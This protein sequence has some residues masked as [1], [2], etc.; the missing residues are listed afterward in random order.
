MTP[1]TS[2]TLTLSSP[3]SPCPVSCIRD[4]AVCGCTVRNE[5][6]IHVYVWFIYPCKDTTIE[7]TIKI[8]KTFSNTLLNVIMFKLSEMILKVTYWTLR[9]L[10]K[11]E[12][13]VRIGAL[14]L[15]WRVQISKV[16]YLALMIWCAAN[17]GKQT[18]KCEFLQFILVFVCYARIT[19]MQW[20]DNSNI[21]ID[22]DTQVN[23]LP[24]AC[25]NK[26]CFRVGGQITQ[27]R[28]YGQRSG[29][30]Q[31]VWGLFIRPRRTI[32][33][34]NDYRLPS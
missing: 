17:S 11:L 7:T 5:H 29:L 2:S 16:K 26:L 30:R 4:L 1:W 9:C 20:K 33:F 12:N 14:R 28:V 22:L 10:Y 21:N 18:R 25:C 19:N 27:W 15:V 23:S 34:M 24:W 8:I 32:W 31:C 3:E 13:T 6:V